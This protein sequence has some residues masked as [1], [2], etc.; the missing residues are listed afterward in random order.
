MSEIEIE[1]TQT[2]TNILKD[3]DETF[4][5]CYEAESGMLDQFEEDDRFY[6]GDQWFNM[7]K[8]VNRLIAEERPIIT[9]N[10]TFKPVNIVTGY[11]RQNKMDLKYYPVEGADQKIADIYTET[12]KW[13]MENAGGRE[14]LAFTFGDSSR[15]GLGWTNVEMD[16]SQ[17][18][19]NGD[20]QITS[21]DKYHFMFDPYMKE[22]TLSDC[23]YILRYAW[24]SKDKACNLYPNMAKEIKKIKPGYNQR[25]TTQM[26]GGTYD[27]A[28]RINIIEKW[29][30]VW[31]KMTIIID[32]VTFESYEW[33][34]GKQKFAEMMS[35][36]PGLKDRIQIIDVKVPRIKLITEAEGEILIY[37]GNTPEG[38]SDN[39]YPFIPMFCYYVPN[40]ND[41]TYKVQGIV[42][43]LKDPQREYNKLRSIMMDAAM[44]VPNSGWV[45]KTGVPADP[46]QLDKTGGGVKIELK[47]GGLNDGL[48]PVQPPQLNSVLTQLHEQHRN[49][50][51][52]IGP[53]ADMLGMI[54]ADQGAS[55][56]D[57]SGMAL[58][59]RAKQGLMSLQNP[60]DG[61]ALAHRVL[62]RY[63]IQMINRWSKEKIQRILGK[64]IP[65]E[66]D[67]VKNTARFDVII[68]TQTSSPTYRLAAYAQLQALVQHGVQIPPSVLRE[69]ADIPANVRETWMA[70]EQQQMQQ[71]LKEKED[72]KQL[73]IMKLKIM[74]NSPA[75]AKEVEMKSKKEIKVMDQAG[76]KDLLTMELMNK[77]AIEKMKLKESNAH[78]G[79]NN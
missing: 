22:P 35:Q 71:A 39:M 7:G 24:L 4:K 74:A 75:L 57:A 56:A 77:L 49:D 21:G 26:P 73:E 36:V 18:P 45:Y 37:N 6:L 63:L 13:I 5:E 65:P 64:P 67:K 10:Q 8:E 14:N 27:R 20:I 16:Y 1:L 60:F 72:E 42:R 15:V 9:I 44:S 25:F 50:I 62:G 2:D 76:D 41:W 51:V 30:R 79:Q 12:A 19:I 31:E 78:Q 11:Y 53:N 43:S 48:W 54:G 29:Y 70:Q 33:K 17:D 34:G 32:P 68:D 23:D 61:A 55:S 40:F 47:T 59:L 69:V 52:T 3:V 28:T 38:F 66:F 58:Q 46:T